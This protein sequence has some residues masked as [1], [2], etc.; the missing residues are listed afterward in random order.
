MISKVSAS[1]SPFFLSSLILHHPLTLIIW[2]A[3]MPSFSFLV[4]PRSFL[5]QDIC[6]CSYLCLEFS[7]S[8]PFTRPLPL[9]LQVPT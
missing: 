9:I 3:P 6:M 1:V 5:P 7:S 2:Q 8:Q 4:V